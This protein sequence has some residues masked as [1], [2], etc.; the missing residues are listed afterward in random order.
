MTW[1]L[2]GRTTPTDSRSKR[3]RASRRGGQVLTRARSATYRNGLP[4]RVR[5]RMP[6]GPDGRTVLTDPEAL[7]SCNES[8]VERGSIWGL[9]YRIQ[10]P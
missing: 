10:M 7:N 1:E 3:N 2:G 4:N 8:V 9:S 5:S 6:C